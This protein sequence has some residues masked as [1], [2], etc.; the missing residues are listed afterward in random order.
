MPGGH[1]QFLVFQGYAGNKHARS[2][3]SPANLH[4]R[5]AKGPVGSVPADPVAKSSRIATGH[6]AD[7]PEIFT[8]YHE[9]K[10]GQASKKVP[11]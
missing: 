9:W 1:F 2:N 5:I 3:A 11:S 7:F 4:S 6:L 10:K 8:S